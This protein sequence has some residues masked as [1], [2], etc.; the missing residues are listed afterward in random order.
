[1]KRKISMTMALTLVLSLAAGPATAFA[2]AEAPAASEAATVAE[3]EKEPA[4]TE[5]PEAAS[6]DAKAD[7]DSTVDSIDRTR[8]EIIDAARSMVEAGEEIKVDKLFKLLADWG[9]AEAQDIPDDPNEEGPGAEEDYRKAL[10]Y[11][12]KG[13]DLGD[14]VSLY[15]LGELYFLGEGVEQD[16]GKAMEY[17]QMAADAGDADA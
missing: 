4:A 6:G 7:S 2:S 8:D 10:E 13:A 14:T 9:N 17:Y 5:A 12:Q 3:A 15:A 11:F 1:M 16:Y